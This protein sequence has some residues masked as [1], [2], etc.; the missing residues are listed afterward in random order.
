[1]SVS[2]TCLTWERLGHGCLRV[3]G[4]FSKKIILFYS[5][6][7][8]DTFQ[9]WL[10]HSNVKIERKKKKGT[11]QAGCTKATETLR[12]PFLSLMCCCL[13]S[14]YCMYLPFSFFRRSFYCFSLFSIFFFIFFN[15]HA[16]SMG[17][18]TYTLVV[19]SVYWDWVPCF[20]YSS[21]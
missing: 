18:E 13:L 7:G 3:R 14:S 15:P 10:R 21:C 19:F 4:V 20:H 12:S 8:S 6:H 5:G 1:V 16:C 17:W 2:D 11:L 9:T